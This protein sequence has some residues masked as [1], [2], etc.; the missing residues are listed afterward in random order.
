MCQVKLATPIVSDV[1]VA[2]PLFERFGVEYLLSKNER[3]K[4][5][6]MTGKKYINV[7]KNVF[8]FYPNFRPPHPDGSA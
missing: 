5:N 6:I 8:F 1:P 4:L 7:A 2:D 3:L